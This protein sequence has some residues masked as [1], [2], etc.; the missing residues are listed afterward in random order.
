MIFKDE[1][2]LSLLPKIVF[3]TAISC[4]SLLA[5]YLMFAEKNS[6][7]LVL[8]PYAINGLFLRQILL[9]FCLL[10]YAI[11][12]AITVFVFLKRKMVWI[13]M[14]LVTALMS[15]ALFSF[16]KVGGNSSQPL[17]AIDLIGT[18]FYLFGSWINT[19]SEYTR[20][21]WKKNDA[22]RGKIYTGGL[23]KY[24]MHINYFGDIVLFIGF[25]LIT[26]NISLLLIPSA[27]ALSF[28]FFIIPKLDKYLEKKY[29]DQF[30]EYAK[31]T[32][33][34]IPSIY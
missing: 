7:P 2:E 33:K 29:G 5:G 11:R 10:F 6:L 20:Y 12:L 23:F 1:Y 13:E 21:F 19:K 26:Q 15:F 34:L 17:G 32:K 30:L 16:F 22:N 25:A 4:V 9:I 27:M 28:V 14:L 24:S 8:E 18:L 31:K 3:I